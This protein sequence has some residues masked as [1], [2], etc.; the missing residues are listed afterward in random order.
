MKQAYLLKNLVA[1]LL[2]AVVVVAG[3]YIHRSWQEEIRFAEA[4]GV[5]ARLTRI[6]SDMTNAGETLRQITFAD[7]QP[8]EW[9]GA[10]ILPSL[11]PISRGHEIVGIVWQSKRLQKVASQQG[12]VLIVFVKNEEIIGEVDIP[13]SHADTS[14]LST[15]PYT[16]DSSLF[17]QLKDGALVLSESR[18]D[19][20]GGSN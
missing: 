2:L 1:I 3:F 19:E 12:Y 14:S 6:K 9:D 18:P 11:T 13:K 17:V 4:K 5:R 15:G 8:G 20:G 16:Q 7:L 10:Y